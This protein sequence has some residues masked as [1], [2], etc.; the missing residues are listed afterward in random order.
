MNSHLY[1]HVLGADPEQDPVAFGAGV[2]G[3]LVQPTD[4]PAILLTSGC[5]YAVGVLHHGVQRTRTIYKE[6]IELLGK[7]SAW[8]KFLDVGDEVTE[9]SVH[10]DDL[11]AISQRG[12]SRRQLMVAK[13]SDT[14]FQHATILIPQGRS[15]IEDVAAASDALYVR[16]ADAGNGK[17]TRLE[18]GSNQ[19]SAVPQPD[20]SSAWRIHADVRVP[21]VIIGFGSWIRRDVTYA[22]DPVS[23][24]TVD[25]HLESES[26]AAV[27]GFQVSEVQAK[28]YDGTLV[29]LTIIC[30]KALARDGQ[31]PTLMMGYGAYGISMDP[32]FD[33]LTRAW[34][35][36]GCRRCASEGMSGMLG[37]RTI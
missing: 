16:S 24:S 5:H 27:S 36:R 21:G 11:Y 26:T 33:P 37:R 31:S 17:V 2:P 13:L 14:D 20:A 10:G 18:Y 8:T 23:R 12:A 7:Q 1:L 34:L 15:V 9:F 29:P 19:I 4:I 30:K 28:S 22:Y 32:V 35:E 25:T 3:L 6:P